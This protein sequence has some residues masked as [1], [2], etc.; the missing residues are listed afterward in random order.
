MWKVQYVR[1]FAVKTRG[2]EARGI[3]KHIVAPFVRRFGR[4][5]DKSLIIFV[6]RFRLRFLSEI[7]DEKGGKSRPEVT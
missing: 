2:V 4:V 3:S 5:W 7:S 1:E 6:M